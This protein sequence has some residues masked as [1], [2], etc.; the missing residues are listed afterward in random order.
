MADGTAFGFQADA[1]SNTLFRIATG[2]LPG[3]RIS[4]PQYA[5][6]GRGM[7]TC[8]VGFV[9]PVDS[10]NLCDSWRIL[11]KFAKTRPLTYVNKRRSADYADNSMR[12]ALH[13]RTIVTRCLSEVKC[14]ASERM[15]ELFDRHVK[16]VV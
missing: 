2:M 15:D 5:W 10:E 6:F 11:G 4:R 3:I 7:E 1:E 16:I 8:V 14:F 13:C 9:L 12:F